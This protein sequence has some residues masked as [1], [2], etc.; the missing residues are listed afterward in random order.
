MHAQPHDPRRDL[1]AGIHKALRLQFATTLTTLGSTDADDADALVAALDA[2]EHLLV[3]CERHLAHEN[4][5]LHPALE[6]A[7]PGS[8]AEAAAEHAQQAAEVAALRLQS[9]ALRRQPAAAALARLYRSLALFIASNLLHMQH[10]ET[11]HNAALW[12]AYS[13]AELLAIEQRL[14]AAIPLPEVLA[15]LPTLIPALNGGERAELIGGLRTGLPAGLFE[16][17]MAVARTVLAPAALERL[18]VALGL[19]PR[20]A[21]ADE[22]VAA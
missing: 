19:G 2:V 7:R 14:V 22:P 21:P 1:Y 18:E 8:S 16:Q 20:T 15:L 17:V 10:E 9:D 5:F 12:A 3:A 13:D 4:E 11:V 6:Q